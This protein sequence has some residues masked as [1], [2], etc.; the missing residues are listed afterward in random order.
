MVLP[1][2]AFLLVA[3]TSVPT[4]AQFPLRLGDAGFMCTD[5][6]PRCGAGMTCSDPA[7]TC[8]MF[9][10][11]YY[12]CVDLGMDVLCCDD[13]AECLGGRCVGG[14]HKDIRYLR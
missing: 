13:G 8:E 11:D 7:R 5:D 3:V 9:G 14:C 10:D 6:A 2:L 4:S 12:R 1:G